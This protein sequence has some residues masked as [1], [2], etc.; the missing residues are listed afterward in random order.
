MFL[1]ISLSLSI[2]LVFLDLSKALEMIQERLRKKE[3]VR[4]DSSCPL[5]AAWV[6]FGQLFGQLVE[7]VKPEAS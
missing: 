3:E 6:C 5:L 7:D 2:S 4:V 1:D